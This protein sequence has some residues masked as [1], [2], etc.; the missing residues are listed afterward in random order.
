MRSDTEVEVLDTWNVAN[1]NDN[2]PDDN[3]D[4]FSFNTAIVNG[5][6]QCR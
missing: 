1:I 3:M 2:V 4:T 6:I 5:R